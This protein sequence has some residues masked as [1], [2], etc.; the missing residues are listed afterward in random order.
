MSDDFDRG[1]FLP[2][3]QLMSFARYGKTFLSEVSL[4][5]DR[6]FLESLLAE[7]R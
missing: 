6:K 5:S 3:T 2:G 7:A 4:L 1:I